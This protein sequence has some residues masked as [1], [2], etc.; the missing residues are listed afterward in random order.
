MFRALVNRRFGFKSVVHL[1]RYMFGG[2]HAPKPFDWRDDHSLN[3]LYEEDPRQTGIPDP[4]AYGQP[5]ES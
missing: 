5:F 2:G 1:Q 4:Y 3:P